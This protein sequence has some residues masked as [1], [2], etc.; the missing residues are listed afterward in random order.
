LLGVESIGF[1][2]A[3]LAPLGFLPL[4]S[5][6]RLFVGVP[7]FCVLCLSDI[8]NSPQHHFHAPLIP[9][10]LWAAAAGLGTIPRRRDQWQGFWRQLRRSPPAN[11]ESRRI[12]AAR[13]AQSG[14]ALPADP[15]AESAPAP[16]SPRDVRAI[17]IAALWCLLSSAGTGLFLGMSPAAIGFW[18]P[19]SRAYWRSLYVPGERARHFP[20]ALAEIPPES[21]VAS[22]DF[23]HPRFTHFSRSYDYSDYRPTVP[24]DADYIVID[25][26]HPYSRIER[27]D[28]VKEYR[29][30]P[31]EWELL[32]DRT[33]GY[34]IILRRIRN[35]SNAD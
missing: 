23:I 4:L 18:D 7:L 13:F 24:D 20:A 30:H 26:R 35:R 5:P 25:T 16:P 28:Q 6:G 19:G 34:F 14:R 12:T 9:V 29:D 31:D 3:L 2:L 27:P 21:R 8:T 1:A 10:L 33:D 22:T 11:Q 32:P 15:Q 17:D